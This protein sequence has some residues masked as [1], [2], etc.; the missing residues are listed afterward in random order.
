MKNKTNFIVES[1]NYQIYDYIVKLLYLI[2]NE[3]VGGE[4]LTP[5]VIIEQA[6]NK[7]WYQ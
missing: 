3:K 1:C 6:S 4:P 7:N 5:I 2:V